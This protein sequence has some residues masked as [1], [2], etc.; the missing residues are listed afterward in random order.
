MSPDRGW[1]KRLLV[2]EQTTPPVH[3]QGGSSWGQAP[4][5][6][7][8]SGK[9]STVEEDQRHKQEWKRWTALR[10]RHASP[11][12]LSVGGQLAGLPD[13]RCDVYS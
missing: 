2:N 5:W 6:G 3:M 10:R 1:P 7:E 13:Y 11:G 12:S 4:H 9:K 8:E